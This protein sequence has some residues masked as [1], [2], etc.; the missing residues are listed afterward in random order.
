MLLKNTNVT[1]V[2]NYSIPPYYF[3]TVKTF[4]FKYKLTWI[5]MLLGATGGYLYYYFWGCNSGTC[6]I[7]SSPLNS[8]IYGTIMGAFLLNIFEPSKKQ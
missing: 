1:K 8:T 6:S 7:T 4:I 5:G 2:P 3:C